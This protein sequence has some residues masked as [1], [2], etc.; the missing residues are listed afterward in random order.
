MVQPCS[1]GDAPTSADFDFVEGQ[2]RKA[3]LARFMSSADKAIIAIQKWYLRET[4]TRGG[5][6]ALAR[7]KNGEVRVPTSFLKFV[8]L[9]TL[10]E[11]IAISSWDTRSS[12]LPRSPPNTPN[13]AA[14]RLRAAGSALPPR[15]CTT[16]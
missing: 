12:L 9:K 1:P 15:E 5:F 6:A 8:W 4:C 11:S 3:N 2:H 13:T 7:P 16:F 10:K 14:E